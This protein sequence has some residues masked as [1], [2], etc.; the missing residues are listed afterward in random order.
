MRLHSVEVVPFNLSH[1]FFSCGFEVNPV[2]RPQAI[3][4]GVMIPDK[5]SRG[6]KKNVLFWAPKMNEFLSRKEFIL[7][8]LITIEVLVIFPCFSPLEQG[9]GCNG[10]VFQSKII[11]DGFIP[12]FF[13]KVEIRQEFGP[14][15]CFIV[16]NMFLNMFMEKFLIAKGRRRCISR[17]IGGV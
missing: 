1:E 13:S 5:N 2:S 10:L 4:T 17:F 15:F 12:S 6:D 14:A 8:G 16:Q 7:N 9:V 3:P 11:G